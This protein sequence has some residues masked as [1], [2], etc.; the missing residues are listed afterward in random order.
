M[1]GKYVL[2]VE[3][4]DDERFLR[5]VLETKFNEI[6]N[7]LSFDFY[8]L[9]NNAHELAK[10]K[11]ALISRKDAGSE[12]LIILD[13]DCQTFEET[14]KIIQENTSE[15]NP[16]IFL[17]PNNGDSGRLETLLKQIVP[18]ENKGYFECIQNYRSCISKLPNSASGEFDHHKEIFV[19]VDSIKDAGSSKGVERDYKLNHVWD[20]NNQSIEPLCAFL[21]ANLK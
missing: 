21:R 17:F 8:H 6:L 13:A 7:N 19:Y 11:T 10:R 4:K 3:G 1:A 5:A 14:L 18:P 9:T 15:I 12:I 2:V 20:L 16:K